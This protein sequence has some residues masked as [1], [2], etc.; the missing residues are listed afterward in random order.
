LQE[1]HVTILKER[2]ERQ[3]V[4]SKALEM[5]KGMKAKWLTS[6]QQQISDLNSQLKVGLSHNKKSVA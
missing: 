4:E 1:Y 6:S 3:E 2:N 5:V